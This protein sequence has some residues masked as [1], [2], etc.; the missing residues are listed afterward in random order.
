MPPPNGL[1]RGP[2]LYA[3]MA[4]AGHRARYKCLLGAADPLAALESY[5]CRVSCAVG[6][7]RRHVVADAREAAASGVDAREA[8]VA[9]LEQ[10]VG[11]LEAAIV[12][13]SR[14]AS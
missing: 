1:G 8:A 5:C 4:L 11:D 3:G 6:L 10:V 13:E 14:F 9:A 7:D 12:R 2:A